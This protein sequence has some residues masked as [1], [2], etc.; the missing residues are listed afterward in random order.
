MTASHYRVCGPRNVLKFVSLDLG[1]DA[2]IICA[3][4][5]ETYLQGAVFS[6][7]PNFKSIATI[8]RPYNSRPLQGRQTGEGECA[9]VV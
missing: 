5:S 8:R 3:R 9:L 2:C 7:R 4:Y 6:S 1:P